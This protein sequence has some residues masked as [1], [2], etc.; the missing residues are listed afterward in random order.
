MSS[1]LRI[2]VLVLAGLAAAI[3]LCAFSGRLGELLYGDEITALRTQ[4]DAARQEIA[5]RTRLNPEVFTS[6][7]VSFVSG[8]SLAEVTV[9][10]PF[11]P[12]TADEQTLRT[13]SED[14]VRKHV[15]TVARIHVVG[16][17]PQQGPPRRGP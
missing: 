11:V 1:A 7:Q 13:I 3:A 10:F 16:S 8:L 12:P 17:G 2:A 4:A 14:A 5:E 6:Y 15:K 9:N